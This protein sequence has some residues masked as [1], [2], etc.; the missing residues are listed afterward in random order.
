M[1][2][3]VPIAI[4]PQNVTRNIGLRTP[5]PPV[6]APLMEQLGNLIDLDAKTV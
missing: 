1:A 5:A 3:V 4:A 6:C 2:A